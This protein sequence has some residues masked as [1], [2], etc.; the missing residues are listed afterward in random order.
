M[1]NII[2]EQLV[3]QIIIALLTTT[4]GSILTYVAAIKKSKNEI[5][6]VRIQAENEIQKIKVQTE[7]QIKLKMADIEM[8]S[9]SDED[10]IKA[11]YMDTFVGEFMNNPNEAI[12]KLESMQKAANK[13]PRNKKK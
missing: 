12:K 13:I 8:K 4:F 2:T 7:E 5:M 10:N 6:A 9:K 1:E 11:K 3:I